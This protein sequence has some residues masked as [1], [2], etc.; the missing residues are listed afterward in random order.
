M[1]REAM[2]AVADPAAGEAPEWA[3]QCS[4]TRAMSRSKKSSSATNRPSVEQ[5]E[6]VPA[7]EAAESDVGAEASAFDAQEQMGEMPTETATAV[8]AV[9]EVSSAASHRLAPIAAITRAGFLPPAKA[10]MMAAAPMAPAETA[11][12][13]LEGAEPA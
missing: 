10:V 9:V 2:E 6:V 1:Q 7:P 3:G 13:R 5:E 12:A 4:L 11:P 8:P